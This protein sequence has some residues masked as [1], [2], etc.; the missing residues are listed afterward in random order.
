MIV[1]RVLICPGCDEVQ[2]ILRHLLQGDHLTPSALLPLGSHMALTKNRFSPLKSISP[3]KLETHVSHAQME[4]GS[5]L[6]RVSFY[7][8]TR[9]ALDA[10]LLRLVPSAFYT[11][12]AYNLSGLQARIPMHVSF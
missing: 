3:L 5:N 12:L 7:L 11:A 4:A 8:L 6:Y 9:L 2:S 10:V 1:G